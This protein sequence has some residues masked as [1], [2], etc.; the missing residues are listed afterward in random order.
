MKSTDRLEP[1]NKYQLILAIKIL[2]GRVG[3]WITL[4]A[5]ELL[6]S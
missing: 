5:L 1:Y 2:V 3:I 4:D 6:G